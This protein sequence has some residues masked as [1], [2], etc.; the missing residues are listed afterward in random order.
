MPYKKQKAIRSNKKVIIYDLMTDLGL[1]FQ[2]GFV[3]VIIVFSVTMPALLLQR[4]I[5]SASK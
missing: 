5:I 4:K 1:I 2:V 3:L